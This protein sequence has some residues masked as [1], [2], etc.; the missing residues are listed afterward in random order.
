[1]SRKANLRNRNSDRDTMRPE[2]DFSAGVRGATARRY[3]RGTNIAVIDPG[4][5]DVY[6]EWNYGEPAASGDRPRS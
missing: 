1:M 2:Y 4:V 6:P 5:L 3:A